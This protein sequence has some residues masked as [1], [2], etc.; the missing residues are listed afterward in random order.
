MTGTDAAPGD[1]CLTLLVVGEDRSHD[2][3]WAEL[4]GCIPGIVIVRQPENKSSVFFINANIQDNSHPYLLVI[5]CAAWIGEDLRAAVGALIDDLCLNFPSWGICANAGVRPD[6]A[7][8]YNYVRRPP[9]NPEHGV[10]PK[11]VITVGGC[12]WLLNLNALRLHKI[13]IPDGINVQSIGPVI[14]HLCLLS[15]LLT[16]ADRRL[17]AAHFPKRDW[18]IKFLSRD[19]KLRRILGESLINHSIPFDVGKLEISDQVD[20]SALALP[21]PGAARKDLLELFDIA[22]HLARPNA[23]KVEIIVRT[24]FRRLSLLERT[25][26]SCAAAALEGGSLC[27]V[28]VRLVSDRPE[29]KSSQIERH[30]QEISPQMEVT[31]DWFSVRPRRHSRTDL[32][33]HA[34]ETSESDYIL[35]VDDDDFVFPG[36]FPVLGRVLPPGAPILA[37]GTTR[38]YREVWSE[39]PAGNNGKR[40]SGRALKDFRSGHSI[41]SRGILRSF[42]GENYIPICGLVMPREQLVSRLKESLALGDYLEDYFMLLRLLSSSKL[43]LEL[44]DCDFAGISHRELENTV[45]ESDRSRWNASYATFFQEL[46]SNNDIN[47]MLWQFGRAVGEGS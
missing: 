38:T 34:I 46:S 33:L 47:P 10:S 39:D 31:V 37:V 30:L 41:S 44:F 18:D 17:I 15:G 23:P 26:A 35:F 32:M 16:L 7:R 14:G 27:G 20:F 43:E 22:L 21:R 4:S 1:N 25:V 19:G 42:S 12:L 29:M 2:R 45:H 40:F 6:G 13:A 3:R 36:A 8:T 9:L 28:R 11:P 24:Q 5:D